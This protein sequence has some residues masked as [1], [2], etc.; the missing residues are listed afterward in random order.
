MAFDRFAG[1]I[2]LTLQKSGP[3]GPL[4]FSTDTNHMSSEILSVL[5]YMEKEKGI[6]R[7]DMIA[8][9]AMPLKT[10]AQKGL[11]SG[12]ELK[13][14]INPKNGQLQAWAV[15]KV[16]DSVSNPRTEIHIE[17][18]QAVKPGAVL[19]EMIERG[20][21]PLL[22]GP[23]RRPDRAP[24]R[25]AAPAAVRKG[26]HLRRFQ[27]PGRQHRHR[28]RPPP[29]AQRHLR[30]PRQGRGGD[31]PPAS[32]CRARNTSRATGSAPSSSRSRTPPG[33]RRSS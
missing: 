21:R 28:H 14:E 22:P 1:Y 27:G 13:I 29:R 26:P 20:D 15:L 4:F 8:T 2:S 31:A 5:E 6:P 17:K 7:G 33:A 19:G 3:C 24:G 11:N 32:R 18:A 10:A 25:D 12:Q 23:H 9:I 30:R 16:V